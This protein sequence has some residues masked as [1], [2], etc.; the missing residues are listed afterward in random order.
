M[1]FSPDGNSIYFSST[2]PVDI[3]EIPQT[4]HIWKSDKVNG[5][6]S[7]PIF[8]DIPNLRNKLVSHPTITNTGELYFHMS[9]LDYSEMNIYHSIR[10]NGKFGNAKKTP[11]L[12][13]S[14][15]GKCTPYI[16][17]KGDY[18]IFATIG[19]QLELMISFSDGN[20][21]WKHP[22]K[23]NDYINTNGQGNPYVTPDN[24]FL[25]YT[26]GNSETKWSVKWI[27]IESE[28]EKLTTQ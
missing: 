13:H 9:N 23:L 18:L 8:V 19:N 16:S 26:T 3:T 27:D 2:R 1:S 17:P 12:G 15:T 11:I 21:G 28:I 24:Q 7:T 14:E 5:K 4:W 25:F 6:W 20:G 22:K 10:N